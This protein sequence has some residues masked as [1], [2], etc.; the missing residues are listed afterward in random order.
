MIVSPHCLYSLFIAPSA[1]FCDRTD[2]MNI[3]LSNLQSKAVFRN[4]DSAAS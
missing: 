2:N 4:M 3:I 1:I